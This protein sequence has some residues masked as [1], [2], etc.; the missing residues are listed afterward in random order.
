[1]MDVLR[2]ACRGCGRDRGFLE[3]EEAPEVGEGCYFYRCALCRTP[4]DTR[5]VLGISFVIAA[6]EDRCAN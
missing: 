2:W 6:P 3:R 5:D 1:M 4:A